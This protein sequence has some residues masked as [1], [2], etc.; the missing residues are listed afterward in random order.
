MSEAEALLHGWVVFYDKMDIMMAFRVFTPQLREPGAAETEM[1]GFLANHR[2]L[3]VDRRFVEEG[4]RS[5]WSF[6]GFPTDWP[7]RPPVPA[8]ASPGKSTIL[9]ARCW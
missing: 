1:N 9:A 5:F 4:E 3:S 8:A 6:C 7:D 2:V